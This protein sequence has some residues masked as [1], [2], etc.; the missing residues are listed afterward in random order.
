M[1]LVERIAYKLSRRFEQKSQLGYE[2]V[3]DMKWNRL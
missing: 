2:N 1:R 3:A